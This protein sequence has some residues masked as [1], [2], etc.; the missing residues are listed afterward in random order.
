M[1]KKGNAEL[2]QKLSLF[3][4]EISVK[5]EISENQPFTRDAQSAHKNPGCLH[6]SN[7]Y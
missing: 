5:N 3:K 1:R 4:K 7:K 6:S 2:K